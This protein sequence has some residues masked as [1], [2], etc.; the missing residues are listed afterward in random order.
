MFPFVLSRRPEVLVIC[1]ANV[2]R[3][4][5]AA[6]ML[7][8]ELRARGA[9]RLCRVV[10]AGTDVATPGRGPDPRMRK[11]AAGSGLS[12]RGER[13][14]PLSAEMAARA[15]LIVGME[16]RHLEKVKDLSP[17]VENTVQLR[18]LGEWL[19]LA[20]APVDISDPYYSNMAAVEAA[21]EQISDSVRNLASAL[22]RGDLEL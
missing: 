7:R 14:L 17:G 21:F 10:S 2:C 13:A 18:R 5:V 8:A 4:P 11:L 20:Q 6:A 9:S 22:V 1:T 15:R 16:Q 3:S 19:D 12:L